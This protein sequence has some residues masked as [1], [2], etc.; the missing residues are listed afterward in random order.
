[1]NKNRSHADEFSS[2]QFRHTWR[3][4]QQRVLSAVHEHLNDKRLH[5]VAAPGAG[6]TTLGLEV[7]RLLGKKTVVLSPTRIIRDQWVDRLRDF[8]EGE[9]QDLPWVSRDILAP[10]LF[11]SITYQALH[12]KSQ[13]KLAVNAPS[14]DVD[15]KPIE[16]DNGLAT[17][18]LNEFITIIKNN[19]IKVMILDEAHHLRSQWWQAL[20]KVCD[21]FPDMVIVSLTA[22]P[23]YGSA[24]SEWTKY[25]KLCGSIDDEISIPEL[26][27]VNTLCPHQD[28]VWLCDVTQSEKSKIKEHDSRVTELCQKLNVDHRLE[29]VVQSHALLKVDANAKPALTEHIQ[30]VVKDPKGL[31]SLLVYL[32]HKQQGINPLVLKQLDLS[33]NDIPELTR[34]WWQELLRTLMLSQHD[35]DEAHK[36]YLDSLKKQLRALELLKKNELSLQRSKRLERSLSLSHSKIAACVEL[37]QLEHKYRRETLRQVILTDYIRDESLHSDMSVG[38]STLGAY[39]VF[40]ALAQQSPIKQKV[41]LITG[42]VSVVHK[43][44]LPLLDTELDEQKIS[45]K[46]LHSIDT[47]GFPATQAY[48]QVVGSTNYLTQLFTRLLIQGDVSVLIGTRALLG[49]GWDAPVIN[50]LILASGVGSFMVTN[51]MRGRAIRIDKDNPTKTS[52]IWHIAAVDT[53]TDYGWRDFATLMSR[54]DM[55]VGLSEYDHVIESGFDRVNTAPFRVNFPLGSKN[56]IKKSNQE[57]HAR[58]Q[59]LANIGKRWQSALTVDTSGRVM[60]TVKTTKTPT[61]RSHLLQHSFAYILLQITSLLMVGFISIARAKPA[62]PSIFLL[63]VGIMIVAVLL[64]K[65]PKTYAVMKVAVSHLPIDGALKQIAKALVESLCNAQ[66][67]NTPHAQLRIR[68]LEQ[69]DGSF[70]VSLLGCSFYESS[71]FSDCMAEILSPIE[72]PRYLVVREGSFMWQ[73]RYDYHAVPYQFAMK[74]STAEIF[75]N[76]WCK[77]VSDS[78][79]VYTRSDKGRNVLVKAKVKAFSSVFNGEVKRQERWQ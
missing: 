19:H 23:P 75:H 8:H 26:V 72:S 32:K 50:S 43:D 4:Y 20:Q 54:F 30:E 69:I 53:D 16:L 39:P 73:T 42:R 5:I 51:Q 44:V 34:T 65:L 68:V 71:L 47:E 48:Y 63:F 38:E 52:S 6:K 77:H 57:M 2:M 58:Y 66:L 11:T 14:T 24:A 60:P 55:F 40:L 1:M 76:A 35:T 64:Y 46:P 12:A 67:I 3:P 28:Y 27:K 79:L 9:P 70:N 59:S 29:Q 31:M 17:S 45:V 18:K 74:K 25:E 33:Y 15:D 36:R 37:H 7:F 49:E 61:L 78:E 41:A 10:A 21:R 62:S 22:T 13:N 56:C